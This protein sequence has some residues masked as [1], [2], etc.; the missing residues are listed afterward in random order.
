M[1]FNVAMFSK[2][3]WGVGKG[4]SGTISNIINAKDEGGNGIL[5]VSV[6]VEQQLYPLGPGTT[7]NHNQ[8]LSYGVAGGSTGYYW[9]Q[10]SQAPA[11]TARSLGTVNCRIRAPREGA[12][13]V[14]ESGLPERAA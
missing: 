9:Q 4:K 10:T 8:L 5:A 12:R 13:G 14:I 11:E 2:E 7:Y 1:S 3:E 6:R